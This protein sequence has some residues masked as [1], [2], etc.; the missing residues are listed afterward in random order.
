VAGRLL[1]GC[2]LLVALTGL[3]MTLFYAPPDG[4]GA[5]HFVRMLFPEAGTA[6]D[7]GEKECDSPRGQPQLL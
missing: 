5:L 6:F 2:G 4:T 7:I 3:W 1:V